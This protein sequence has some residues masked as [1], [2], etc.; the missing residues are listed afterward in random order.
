MPELS[1]FKRS[2]K[3]CANTILAHVTE[4]SGKR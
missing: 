1:K 2:D 4:S 3:V